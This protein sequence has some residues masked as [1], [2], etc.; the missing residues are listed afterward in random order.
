MKKLIYLLITF[1]IIGCSN[2][3]DC[4]QYPTLTT[5]EVNNFTDTSANISGKIIAPTCDDTVTSQGFVFSTT[6]LPKIDDNVIEKNGTNISATITNL[7]QNTTYYVR[8]FF[9]NTEG[10]FYGNEID[11]KTVI[12]ETLLT[13]NNIIQITNN[14]AISGGNITSDGGSVIT[15]RGV[16][17]SFSENP[18]IN[19]NKTN[20]GEGIGEFSSSL[21]N[22]ISNTT[23]Y[24]RS[25]TINELGVTYG[26]EVEFKTDCDEPTGNISYDITRENGIISFNFNYE[27][28][29]PSGNYNVQSIKLSF[30]D[31]SNNSYEKE[32]DINN[33]NGS[34]V[35]S[36]LPPKKTFSNIKIEVTSSDC[37]L[38]NIY[39]SVTSFQTPALYDVGDLGEG[40]IIIYMNSNGI[41]GIA[42]SD[43]DAG[44]GNWAC[45]TSNSQEDF[46]WYGYST[47]GNTINDWIGE[48]GDGEAYSY[49]ILDF[50]TNG[51]GNS[52][53]G[54]FADFC[55]CINNPKAV[56]LATNLTK[57]GYD[58]WYLP[59]IKT[60][61]LIYELYE[62]GTISGFENIN[63]PCGT[64]SEPIYVSSSG[65]GAN[66]GLINFSLTGNYAGKVSKGSFGGIFKVRPVRKF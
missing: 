63:N 37:G 30:N 56:E 13:T 36:N 38:T 29:L 34:S 31:N 32:L 47:F 65:D 11:F 35:I 44:E 33:L 16:C 66:A 59:H 23:Y 58:D 51:T 4:E 18:T 42:V 26:N 60:L 1:T 62:N 53:N 19:D 10:V 24:V 40:G 5:D 3:E 64:S 49:A 50:L 52:S 27:I 28:E 54:Y 45:D 12:G 20:D 8:T 43:V 2:E 9:E 6:T 21:T 25:Y 61:N 17:W 15:D 41:N 57:D 14:S 48:I 55:N 39:P 22:L 46:G 7:E